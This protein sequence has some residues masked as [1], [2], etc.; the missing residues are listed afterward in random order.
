MNTLTNILIVWA[1]L[2]LMVFQLFKDDY[3]PSPRQKFWV[4]MLCGP[5]FWFILFAYCM[6][7]LLRKR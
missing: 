1:I 7:W 3:E 2:G 5:C 6:T 4:L